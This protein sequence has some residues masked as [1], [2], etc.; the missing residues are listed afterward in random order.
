MREAFDAGSIYHVPVASC[1]P[2]PQ[3]SD[4]NDNARA[5]GTRVVADR[6]RDSDLSSSLARVGRK[7]GVE[8]NGALGD[9]TA[10]VNRLY[11]G[12]GRGRSHRRCT[13]HV[14]QNRVD[15]PR[16]LLLGLISSAALQLNSYTV[17]YKAVV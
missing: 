5:S 17:R 13:V 2:F 11:L 6:K 12:L 9:A 15:G 3:L 7:L 14:E 4:A 8:L 10:H 1:G 16:L